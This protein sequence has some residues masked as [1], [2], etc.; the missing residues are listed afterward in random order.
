MVYHLILLQDKDIFCLFFFHGLCDRF[1]LVPMFLIFTCI[2]D[3]TVTMTLWVF[4]LICMTSNGHGFSKL[5]SFRSTHT[6]QF[7]C[8][9]LLR[10]CESH[11]Y[12]LLCSGPLAVFPLITTLVADRRYGQRLLAFAHFMLN[13]MSD[14]TLL[15]LHIIL[16]NGS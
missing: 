6:T 12:T 8:C 1:P 5:L 14:F 7:L 4:Y 9:F 15:T 3:I 13:V 16:L 2:F 11:T 10:K